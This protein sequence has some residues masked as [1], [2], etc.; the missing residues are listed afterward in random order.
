MD[1]FTRIAHV[2]VAV[3]NLPVG[4]GGTFLEPNGG[5]AAS[6]AVNWLD[7]QL[8]SDRQ[9]AG[10]FVGE[11]CGL[12]PDSQWSLQRKQF[13]A[14]ASGHC[15]GGC[16]RVVRCARSMARAAESMLLMPEL[17]SWHAYSN[18]PASSGRDFM[19]SAAVHGAVH[20]VA[21]VKVT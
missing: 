14:T 11:N 9:S 19:S 16:H 20:V 12:C 6:V 3:A 1:D 18:T 5:A 15:P 2:P 4:H 7:W 21:S 10:R 8:R 17:P 13:P